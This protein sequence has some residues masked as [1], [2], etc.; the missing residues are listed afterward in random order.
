MAE[1]ALSPDS[2]KALLA[3]L[4]RALRS[5]IGSRELRDETAGLPAELLQP[6][7]VFV[8]L[9]KAGRLRGCIG[10]FEADA[11]LARIAV[12]MGAAAVA[13]DP[14]FPPVTLEEL[15]ECEIEVS[16]LSP[17][18]PI[19]SP[20]EIEIGVH[21][22]QLERGMHRAVFLPQVAPEQRWDRDTMLDHLCLK[23]GLAADAW[24]RGPVELAVFTAEVF[25][26]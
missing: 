4:R 22:V 17:P 13:Q 15:D 3:H 6:A 2:R 24:R 10:T 19:A 21:G 9:H 26:E 11:P 25:S 16:V 1:P 18:R 5:W 14:R 20:D 23:A 12:R 7:G 8:T